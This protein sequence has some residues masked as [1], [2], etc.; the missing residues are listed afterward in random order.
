MT[1]IE[2]TKKIQTLKEWKRMI[3]EAEAEAEKL[4][5]EIK[6]EML[7]RDTEEMDVGTYIVRYTVVLTDR[8]DSTSLKK[9]MPDIYNNYLKSTKSRRFSISG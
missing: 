7:L 1:N 6:E 3:K 8:F 5:N 4:E 2:L 9:A